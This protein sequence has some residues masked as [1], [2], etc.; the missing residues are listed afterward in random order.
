[1]RSATNLANY[2]EALPLSADSVVEFHAA[3]LLL[4]MDKCGRSGRISGLTKMAKLDFFVRYPKFFNKVCSILGVE[5]QSSHDTIESKMIRFHYGPW[6]QRYYHVLAYLESRQLVKIE[7]KGKS[8][9]IAL[10]ILGKH[11]AKE[12]SQDEVFQELIEQMIRVNEV[13]GSKL[14][15]QLKKLIYEVFD[16]EVTKLS[17]QEVIE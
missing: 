12:L 11:A 3:R 8:F 6:D 1:M 13:L 15:S 10:T 7:K 17:Y 9:K 14:G 5:I 16:E 2:P 4:L